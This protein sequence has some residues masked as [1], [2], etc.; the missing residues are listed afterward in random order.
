LVSDDDG[1]PLAEPGGGE[2]RGIEQGR[3]Q[4]RPKYAIAEAGI[5]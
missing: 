4:R 3:L 1:K 5:T 2:R